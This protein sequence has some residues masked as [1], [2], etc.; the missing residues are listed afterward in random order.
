[1]ENYLV[2]KG[3]GESRVKFV[4]FSTFSYSENLENGASGYFYR[5]EKALSSSEIWCLKVWT[6]FVKSHKIYWKTERS[7]DLRNLLEIIEVFS[8]SPN[9]PHS[10]ASKPFG[11]YKLFYID[12]WYFAFFWVLFRD[13]RSQK[14]N[15]LDLKPKLTRRWPKQPQKAKDRKSEIQVLFASTKARLLQKMDRKT[16]LGE[17][18]NSSCFQANFR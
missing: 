15:F 17:L 9:F 18:G 1:M 7:G 12:I 5:S 10:F 6:Y 8:N 13:T 3:V 11:E 14:W 4:F 2:G 16:K